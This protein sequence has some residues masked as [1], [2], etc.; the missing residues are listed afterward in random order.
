MNSSSL[1]R[2]SG[3]K[4]ASVF[5]LAFNFSFS[6]IYKSLAPPGC[7]PSRAILFSL[8]FNSIALGLCA[9][10]S[11]LNS[12]SRTSLFG[13]ITLTPDIPGLFLKNV[14]DISSN[15]KPCPLYCSLNFSTPCSSSC[16]K[17]SKALSSSPKKKSSAL[18]LDFMPLA[19]R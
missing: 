13:A 11:T 4:L 15:S 8:I 16:E 10:L 14:N 3:T 1:L 7:I 2:W 18:P 19:S 9:K 5:S 6:F 12:S 17:N